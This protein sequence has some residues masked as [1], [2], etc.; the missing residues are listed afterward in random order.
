MPGLN[1]AVDHT[2]KV[3]IMIN[4]EFLDAD[5]G[6]DKFFALVQSMPDPSEALDLIELARIHFSG[7]I[8]NNSHSGPDRMRIQNTL[9]RLNLEK[10]KINKTIRETDVCDAVKAI[11]GREGWA[12]VRE[13]IIINRNREH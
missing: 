11:Y 5:I 13:W 1:L 2:D 9:Q 10:K 3:E 8:A 12:Q 4:P 7:I 6:G